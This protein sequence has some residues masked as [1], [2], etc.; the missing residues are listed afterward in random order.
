[1]ENCS[2]YFYSFFSSSFFLSLFRENFIDSVVLSS[3]R[4]GGTTN[5]LVIGDGS[6]LVL[7]FLLREKRKREGKNWLIVVSEE[8]KVDKDAAKRC[9]IRYMI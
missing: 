5:F 1:M 9:K 6:D 8:V 2:F 7:N 4:G 3:Q